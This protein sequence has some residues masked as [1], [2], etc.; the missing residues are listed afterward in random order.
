MADNEKLLKLDP[1]GALVN[2]I[3]DENR[4]IFNGGIGGELEF[5]QIRPG[6]GVRTDIKVKVRDRRSSADWV[7]APGEIDFTYNRLDVL[8]NLGGYLSGWRPQLPTSTWEV[9]Q[10]LTNRTG[11]IFYK[12]DFIQEDIVRQNAAPYVLK[13]QAGSLR[14]TGSMSLTLVDLIDLGSYLADG[15]PQNPP[16]LDLETGSIP[17]HYVHPYMNGTS[18]VKLLDGLA[19]GATANGIDHPIARFLQQTVPDLGVYLM[20]EDFQDYRNSWV[21]QTTDNSS[22][23]SLGAK[24]LGKSTVQIGLNSLLPAMTSVVN[25]ELTLPGRRS[26]RLIQVPYRQTTFDDSA[27]N[28]TPRLRCTSVRTAVD[29]TPWNVWLNEI[30]APSEFPSIPFTA[31]SGFR[32]TETGEWVNDPLNPGPTNLH[33]AI[34]QYN[35]ERRIQ[36]PEPANLDCN[37]VLSVSLSDYNTAFEGTFTFHYRAPIIVDLPGPQPVNTD[38]LHHL[39]PSEGEG[40]YTVT[41]VSGS[42]ATGHVLQGDVLTGRCLTLGRHRPVIDVTDQRGVTVRYSMQYD[43]VWTPVVLTNTVPA[44]QIGSPW[45]YTFELGGGVPEFTYEL[46]DAPAGFTLSR[47]TRTISGTF[48]GTTGIRYLSMDVSDASGRTTR[49]LI[50]VTVI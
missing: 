8:S 49:V 13:A 2:I 34:V 48:T 29:G 17:N 6:P 14:W 35:G 38:I 33:R 10:E 20:G 37:R 11:L 12:E 40:P 25:I 15:V 24:Y 18:A 22:V 23:N 47:V 32:P 50:P 31:S 44:G 39:N 27:F 21:Y 5:S 16:V 30:T 4:T 46:V 41:V 3:N 9:L 45:S 43:V 26:S 36:D 7:P 1:H 19:V 42:V 28:D